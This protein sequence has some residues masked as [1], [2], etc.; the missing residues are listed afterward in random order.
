M[1]AILEQFRAAAAQADSQGR[2]KVLDFIRNL[3]LTLETPHD[4]LSRFSG[5][6]S[7]GPPYHPSLPVSLVSAQHLQIAVARIGEDLN[8]FQALTESDH[9][10]STAALA[11]KTGAAP[12]L[13]GEC[14]L[15]SY[16]AVH[17]L[18]L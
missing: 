12:L 7:L 14:V 10:W 16:S 8:I 6:V 5:L 2:H 9:P 13:L 3:Q 1:D 11:S 15:T 4:T 18:T 17:W